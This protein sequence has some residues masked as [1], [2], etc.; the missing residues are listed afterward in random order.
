MRINIPRNLYPLLAEETGLHIGDGSM[1]F[2]KNNKNVRGKYSLRGHIIDDKPHYDSTIKELYKKLYNL[3]VKFYSDKKTG[4][5]GFQIWDDKLVN[6]KKNILKLPLGKKGEISIPQEFLKEKELMINVLRG[7]FD[8]DGCL[9]LEKKKKTKYPRV[10]I[11]TTSKV[12]S[13]QI[14][15]ILQKLEIRATSYIYQRKEKNWR[16]LIN[17][18]VRGNINVTKFFKII[19]PNNPKHIK[20]F[21]DFSENLIKK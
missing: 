5:Y 15:V 2:Y 3:E 16:D 19:R 11:T 13:K 4:I 7:I 20:K 21:K 10:K 18:E 6:F 17:I 12:L 9:Y 8:T 1:N 14:L